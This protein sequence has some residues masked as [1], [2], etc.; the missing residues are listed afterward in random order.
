LPAEWFGLDDPKSARAIA[1][2]GEEIKQTLLSQKDPRPSQDAEKHRKDRFEHRAP[3]A[4]LDGN[5]APEKSGEQDGAQN[6]RSWN[7]VDGCANQQEEADAGDKRQGKSEPSTCLSHGRRHDELAH[8]VEKQEEHG[9]GR[10]NAACPQ[11]AARI[12]ARTSQ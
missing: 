1:P 10:E 11:L 3:S 12:G 4:H 5:G 9:D 8:G 7:G 2:Q 6:G